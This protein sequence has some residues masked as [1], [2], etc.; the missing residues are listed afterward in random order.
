MTRLRCSVA[1]SS[2]PGCR[3]AARSSRPASASSGMPRSRPVT[4]PRCSSGKKRTRFLRSSAQRKTAGAFLDV[5]TTPPRSPQN[6]F[7]AA[8]ELMYVTGSVSSAR[9]ASVSSSQQDRTSWRRH[10][11]HRAAGRHV[12]QD[13]L[14]MGRAEDVGALRH[15]VHAAE[16]DV[17][18]LRVA[19]AYRASLKESPRWS[20]KRITSSRW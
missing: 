6:A 8:V 4:R 19:A 14:L 7:S 1:A 11:R 3:A 2:R 12:R 13:D 9:P 17:V 18:R 20:A 5:Q 10:V 15:E 16:D